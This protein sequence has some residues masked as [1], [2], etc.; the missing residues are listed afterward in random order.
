[1]RGLNALVKRVSMHCVVKQPN[2]QTALVATRS[3]D[4]FPLRLSSVHHPPRATALDF[5]TSYWVTHLQLTMRPVSSLPLLFLLSAFTSGFS[6][7]DRPRAAFLE[8]VLGGDQT[9]CKVSNDVLS[10]D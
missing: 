6:A 10:R 8:D 7:L 9:H 4:F 2:S 5:N 1:M 3:L